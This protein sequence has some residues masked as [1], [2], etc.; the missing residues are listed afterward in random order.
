MHADATVLVRAS[1]ISP[2]VNELQEDTL[3]TCAYLNQV[4]P[5]AVAAHASVHTSPHLVNKDP[6][7]RHNGGE[8]TRRSAKYVHA[9]RGPPRLAQ[10]AYKRNTLCAEGLP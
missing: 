6:Q 4:R 1:V 7:L 3:A 10:S 9:P 2:G 8:R 5:H